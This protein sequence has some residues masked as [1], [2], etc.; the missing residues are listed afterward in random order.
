MKKLLAIIVLGLLWCN[1]SYAETITLNKCKNTEYD[2]L[3]YEKYY[4]IIDLKKKEITH[5]VVYDDKYFKEQH[6]A[7]AK[8]PVLKKQLNR[9][10][11]L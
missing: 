4:Y 6:K 5:V 11:L 3:M 7:F 9:I 8:E 1:V 10:Q 2:S